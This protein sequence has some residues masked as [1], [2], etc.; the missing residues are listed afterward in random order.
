VV[1]IELDKVTVADLAESKFVRR[2]RALAA[3]EAAK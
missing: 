2:A 1:S 3:L